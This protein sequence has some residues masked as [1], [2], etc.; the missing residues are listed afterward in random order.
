MAQP[1]PA[2]SKNLFHYELRGEPNDALRAEMEADYPVP[3][4]SLDG[5][6]NPA[7]YQALV[8]DLMSTQYA[9]D[10]AYHA[11][12]GQCEKQELLAPPQ[13]GN[14]AS[15][16]IWVYRPQSLRDD[17]SAPAIVYVHGGGSVGGC[18]ED[19]EPYY[20]H[21]AAS[22]GTVVC[23]IGYRLVPHVAFPFTMLDSYVGVKYVAEN[24]AALGIDPDR[25]AMSGDSAGGLQILA[26][27]A[28]LAQNDESHLVKLARVSVSQILDYF[29]TEPRDAMT[30]PAADAVQESE[31][32][33][34]WMLGDRRETMLREGN[35]LVFPG[36][37]SDELLA[38]YPPFIVIEQEFDNYREPNER[39]AERLRA[40][41]RLLEYICY[42]GCG[43]NGG[44]PNEQSDLVKMYD[45]YL[46]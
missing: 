36:L 34:D 44:H 20:A 29:V 12:V 13:D 25:I 43:H 15:A 42:P 2:D 28:K 22:T 1:R 40:A 38:R 27:A 33:I 24:A 30:K 3:Q 31:T 4:L 17:R 10:P 35:P 18:L 23:A 19:F 7:A 14:D 11:S 37:A 26:V 8:A 6:W 39:L 5:E 21:M 46:K 9:S 16:R 45:V 32:V 41:G